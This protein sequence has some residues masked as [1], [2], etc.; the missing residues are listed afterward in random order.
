MIAA[1][2]RVGTDRHGIG[3]RDRAGIGVVAAEIVDAP[4]PPTPLPYKANASPDVAN[5]PN[6]VGLVV[7]KSIAAPDATRL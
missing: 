5:L 2:G 7:S 6:V 1:G 3:Q 4:V